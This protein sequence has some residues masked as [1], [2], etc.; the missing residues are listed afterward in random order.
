VRIWLGAF[1]SNVGT[2][3]QAICVG[4]YVTETTG[5][6][7]WTGTVAGLTYLP[8]VVLGPIGGALADRFERRRYIAP[9]VMVQAAS[10]LTLAVLSGT[11]HLPLPA[12]GGLVFLNGCASALSTPAFNALLSELVAPEDLLSAVSLSSAQFNL[13]R[14]VGPML[15]AAIL[16]YASLT[17]SFAVN[18]MSYLGVLLALAS[19][20]RRPRPQGPAQGSIWQGIRSGLDVA[21]ADPGIRLALPLVAVLTV[22]IAPFIGLMPAYAIKGLGRGAREA[23]LMAVSQGVGALI[24][25]AGANALAQRLGVR[26]LLQRTLVAVGPVAIAYWLAPSYPIAFAVLAL[27]GAVYILNINALS[28]TCMGRVSRDLQARMSSLH[29]ATLS[30][31][32]ALGLATQGWL[33][34]RLGL[35]LV[36]AVAAAMVL[37]IALVLRQRGAFAA[38]DTV[39]KFGGGKIH[40]TAIE[41]AEAP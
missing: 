31:G 4:I 2:W 39:S 34:D 5:S 33:S 28:A 40:T 1:V 13:A 26:G 35:R 29:S 9:L 15:A 32:Y 38:I 23:S 24:A 37:A 16:T 14:I 41:P 11:G 8:A 6:A 19:I 21:R 20:P 27:L 7:G 3:V 30:G 18:A 25:S 36:P 17:A 10:A 22:L 12:I